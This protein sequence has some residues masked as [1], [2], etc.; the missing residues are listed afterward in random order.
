[1][2][3]NYASKEEAIV[4]A[5]EL[6][7]NNLPE[8]YVVADR[9]L[10]RISKDLYSISLRDKI[11]SAIGRDITSGDMIIDDLPEANASWEVG[12]QELADT[13]NIERAKFDQ[14]EYRDYSKYSVPKYDGKPYVVLNK[15]VPDFTEEEK[16]NILPFERYKNLDSKGRTG[17][18]FANLCKDLMSNKEMERIL[19]IRTSGWQSEEYDFIDGEYLF[20]RCNLINPKLVGENANAKNL[21]TGTRYMRLQGMA[22]IENLVMDYINKTNNHDA[23]EKAWDDINNG[24]HP[25]MID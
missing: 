16:N 7:E 15:N 19:F 9:L 17:V 13:S 6:I 11:I 20:N 3:E 1:M 18:A 10:I 5:E 4:R 2:I 24:I 14:E 25:G 8:K 12:N 21:I 23:L 22:L